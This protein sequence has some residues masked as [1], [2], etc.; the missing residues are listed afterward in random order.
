MS[1][2]NAELAYRVLDQI[3]AH[4]ELWDQAVWD[5]GT[6]A[7][8]AGWAVRLSGETSSNDDGADNYT[9]DV[10]ARLLGFDRRDEMDEITDAAGEREWLFS[11]ENTREDLGRMVEEIFGP[12]PH[13]AESSFAPA[14]SLKD[15]PD[16]M[17]PE[18]E[19]DDVPPNA[20]SAS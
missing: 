2:P 6:T 14:A 10:A 16:P 4:P 1:T 20:G 19:E 9:P 12:R 11:S 8:F 18:G 13:P 15:A 7:C 3:D 17:Y 5:C